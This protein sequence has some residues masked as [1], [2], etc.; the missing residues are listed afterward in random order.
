MVSDESTLR[1]RL[2]DEYHRPLYRAHPERK[3][4]RKIILRQYIWP[5]LGVFINRYCGNCPECRRSW[6]VRFK[7]AGLLQPLLIP[8]RVWQ[9]ITMNFKLFP[10]NQNGY[11]AILVV[12]DRLSKRSFSLFTRKTC[13]AIELADL[14]FMHI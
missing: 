7:P 12:I 14:Y 11:D 3:K 13:T 8:K 4:M 9:H 6:N 10:L 2:C 5:S 1:T